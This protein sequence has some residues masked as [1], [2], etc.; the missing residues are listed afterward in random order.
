MSPTRR[1]SVLSWIRVQAELSPLSI[2]VN[3]AGV[4]GGEEPALDLS[5]EDFDAT[6]AGNVRRT[7]FAAREAAKRMI[8]A[9]VEGRSVNIASIAS[10]AVMPGFPHTAA[11][12]R[13]WPC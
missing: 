1:P 5:I 7:Y 9:K 13:R 2:L 3:T 10:H 6:F 4:G 8:E 12:R 11:R